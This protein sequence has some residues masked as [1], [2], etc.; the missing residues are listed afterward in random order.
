MGE[1]LDGFETVD[2]RRVRMT[3]ERVR[4]GRLEVCRRCP[5]MGE[6][7]KICE[8]CGCRLATKIGTRS[9]ACPQGHW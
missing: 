6:G 8:A 4:E 3:M 9:N 7:E 2:G 5:Y 1:R